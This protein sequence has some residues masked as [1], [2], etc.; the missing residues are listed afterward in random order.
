MPARDLDLTDPDTGQAVAAAPTLRPTPSLGDIVDY[1]PGATWGPRTL[2]DHEVVWLLD[3]TC[4]WW[5]ADARHDLAPGDVLVIPPGVRDALAWAAER[6][7]RMGFVHFD[8]DPPLGAPLLRSLPDLDPVRP[9]LRHTVHLLT[10]PA[11][12]TAAL[13]AETLRTALLL[14]V[15]GA[16]EVP[17]DDLSPPLAAVA[18]ELRRR[19]AGGVMPP[20]PVA[21]LARAA[22]LSPR[23]MGRV[24][25]AETGRTPA[26]AVEALRLRTAGLLLERTNLPVAEVARTCGYTSPYHFSRRFRAAYGVAPR[27][28]RGLAPPPHPPGLHR[29]ARA[30]WPDG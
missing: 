22:A 26:A 11:P 16:A 12:P 23:Q 29:L 24:F 6:P 7:S 14:L 5:T 15:T 9:L 20:V 4:R 2:R 17:R 10:A 3:G 13:A 18:A 8:L 1:P 28:A 25:A 19:W 30:V 21:A 27:D